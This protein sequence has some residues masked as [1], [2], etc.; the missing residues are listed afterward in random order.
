MA[1]EIMTQPPES[2]IYHLS[3]PVKHVLQVTIDRES[4]MNAIPVAGHWEGERLWEWFDEEPSMR[5]AIV[6]GQGRRAFCCGA[7]L[8]EQARLNQS[9]QKSQDQHFPKGGFMG[10]SRRVGKK[11]VIAAV[12]GFAL[13]GGFEI[14]LNCD[15]V[16]ASP[17]A[18]FGLPEAKRG[19]WAA[20]GGIPRVVRIFGMQMASEIVLAG[21]VLSATEAQHHGFCRVSAS[22]ETMIQ[23]ALHLANRV[24][25]MSPDAIIVSRAGLR[26]AWET[27]SVERAAQLVQD[28]Y[29]KGLLEGDNLRIGLRAFVAKTTPEFVP[30]K[31]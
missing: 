30:S 6:T 26:E 9:S 13:G 24:A 29:A 1:E 10:L 8:K 21:K 15:M 20:A 31:L 4:H 18:T 22:P 16:V 23:D 19:L 14:A 17:V 25:S 2:S 12:N 28:R 3:F 27:A 7:D 5:V 11:P